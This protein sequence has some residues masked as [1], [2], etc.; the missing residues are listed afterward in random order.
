MFH[1]AITGTGRA[2]PA[3][4]LSNADLE[5]MV[6]TTDEWITTRTGIRERRMASD[7]EVMTD[8]CLAAAREALATANVA[9]E[10]LDAIMVATVSP[11]QPIPAAACILQQKLG[12]KKVA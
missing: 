1:A 6:E 12:A 4:V 9:P 10:A 2:A 11:D 7:G 3:K 8:F 5:K